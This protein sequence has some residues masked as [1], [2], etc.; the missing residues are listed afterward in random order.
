MQKVQMVYA[1]VIKKVMAEGIAYANERTQNLYALWSLE[2]I[3]SSSRL[4]QIK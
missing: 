2:D 4:P 1:S 3:H